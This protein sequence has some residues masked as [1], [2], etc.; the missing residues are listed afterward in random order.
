MPKILRLTIKKKWFDLLI[1]GIKTEEYRE[2]KPYY[3]RRFERDLFSTEWVE[4]INGYRADSPRAT[5]EL[6]QICKGTGNP[7]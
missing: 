7:E 1:A 6:K 3:Q 4:F 5:F 2:I